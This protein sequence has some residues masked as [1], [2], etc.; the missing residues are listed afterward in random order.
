[1]EVA[2]TLGRGAE[3]GG[4]ADGIAGADQRPF[5]RGG[6]CAGAEELGAAFVKFGAGGDQL[7][8]FREAPDI[9]KADAADETVVL[10]EE[11]LV[12]AAGGVVEG[13]GLDG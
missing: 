8:V 10:D 2:F 11:F 9:A 1:V 7:E 6:L 3:N 5:D 13:D 4:L 12:V